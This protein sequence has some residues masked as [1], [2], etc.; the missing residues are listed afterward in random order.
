MRLKQKELQAYRKKLL[1]EQQ[2]ICPLCG[3]EIH[4]GEDTLD[5]DHKTGHCRRVLHRSCNQVEGRVLSWIKRSRSQDAVLFVQNML[6]YWEQD[7][8]LNPIHPTHL[9][10]KQK[11]IQKLKRKRMKVKTER[12]KQRYTDQIRKLQENNND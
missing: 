12:A 7:Y 4:P 8:S 2:G 6:Q 5:H 1:K 11:Q 3:T 9:S 10:E